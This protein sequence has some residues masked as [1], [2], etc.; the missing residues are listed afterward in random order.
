MPINPFAWGSRLFYGKGLSLMKMILVRSILLGLKVLGGAAAVAALSFGILLV[1]ITITEYRPQ[2]QE[3][4]EVSRQ[5]A[6]L[7][8]SPEL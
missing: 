5:A 4:A 1:F 3:S 7:K 6:I 2:A 8:E